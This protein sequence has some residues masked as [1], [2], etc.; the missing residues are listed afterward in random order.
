MHVVGIDSRSILSTFLS[1]AIRNVIPTAK[2]KGTRRKSLYWP[3]CHF[4]AWL[5]EE[6]SART[7]MGAD[8]GGHLAK[9][10]EGRRAV[11][12]LLRRCLHFRN[13]L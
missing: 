3:A 10:S 13:R 11:A 2:S 4:C 6:F 5:Q 12:E 9:Y 7:E 8:S 1:A